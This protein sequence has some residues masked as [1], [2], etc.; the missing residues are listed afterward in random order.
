[1]SERITGVALLFGKT[2][3]F[4][5]AE[6]APKRHHDVIA[7]ARDLGLSVAA[8][9]QAEQGFWTSEGRFVSRRVAMSIAQDAGQLR[10]EEVRGGLTL[11]RVYAGPELYSEDVW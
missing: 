8:I 11:E 2:A 9:A 4:V 5:V 6:D 7:K 10:R 3:P 1:M